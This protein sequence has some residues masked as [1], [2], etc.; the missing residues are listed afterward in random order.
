MLDCRG[1]RSGVRNLAVQPLGGRLREPRGWARFH[2]EHSGGAWPSSGQPGV[3]VRSGRARRSGGRRSDLRPIVPGGAGSSRSPAA[4]DSCGLG[5]FT[6]NIR[7]RSAAA[8][9]YE[10][11]LTQRGRA[12]ASQARAT[13][14]QLPTRS[15]RPTTR[16]HSATD[17]TNLPIP[18]RLASGSRGGPCPRCPKLPVR[19]ILPSVDAASRSHSNTG[20]PFHL[21]Y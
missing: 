14:H 21:R 10:T 2:V 15:P 7:S 8:P 20:V 16:P 13:Q 3:S 9:L 18:Y 4:A 5:R 11:G 1:P 17:Y 12:P 6:W 19:P